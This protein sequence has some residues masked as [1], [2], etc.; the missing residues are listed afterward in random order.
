MPPV[1]RRRRG[2]A[3]AARA[4]EAAAAAAASDASQSG[5]G[6]DG[7]SQ[8]GSEGDALPSVDEMD[9]PACACL[10]WEVELDEAVTCLAVSPDGGLV[11]AGTADGPVALLETRRGGAVRAALAGHRGGAAGV[12]FAPGAWPGAAGPVLLSCGEDGRVRAWEAGEAPAGG[13]RE[14]A[15]LAPGAEGA[16]GSAHGASVGHLAAVDAG[17]FGARFAAAAGRSV[18]EWRPPGAPGAP[19]ARGRPLAPVPGFVEALRYDTAGSLFAAHRGGVTAWLASAPRDGAGALDLPHQGGACLAVD[20]YPVPRSPTALTWVAGGCHDDTLA[21]WS[22]S[23]EGAAGDELRLTVGRCGGFDGKVV[24]VDFAPGGE[25][26]VGAS[27]GGGALVWRLDA[28]DGAPPTVCVGHRRPVTAQ[29]WAPEADAVE[30]GGRPA[31]LAAAA[32]DG[33]VLLFVPGATR[34]LCDPGAGGAGGQPAICLPA[35][36]ADAPGDEVT[37]LRWGGT[38]EF[39]TAHLSGRVRGWALPE[40]L[41]GGWESGSGS[42]SGSE[43]ESGGG[44]TSSEEEGE[45]DEEEAPRR[46]GKKSKP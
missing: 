42:E 14:L 13:G 43:S 46:R 10:G 33:L 17:A 22:L 8:S 12:A 4:A 32:K 20:A 40:E 27:G 35:A 28:G 26:L 21:I 3:A 45:E 37:A 44:S 36:R 7:G 1:D 5:S 6:S 15:A 29:A 16:D 41:L 39:Y 2:A 30:D 19:P 31:L 38:A 34:Y 23:T 24:A 25:P 9:L 18:T 11:A